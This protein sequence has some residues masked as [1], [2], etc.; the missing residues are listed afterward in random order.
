MQINSFAYSNLHIHEYSVK[1]KKKKKKKHGKLIISQPVVTTDKQNG[2]KQKVI[3]SLTI[4]SS[5]MQIIS[6][7][8]SWIFINT[9]FLA[10]K[11]TT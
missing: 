7:S 4:Y 10:K 8:Y 6:F 3:H 2:I 11:K 9:N 5:Y 1:K